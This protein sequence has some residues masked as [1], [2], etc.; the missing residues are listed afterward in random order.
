MAQGVVHDLEVVEVEEQDDRDQ[1]RGVGRLEAL[2]HALGEERPIGEAGQGI[3]VGLVLELLLEP[4]Q[5][6]ER[7]LQLA[8]LERDRRVA[9]E[10]LEQLE[11][12]G[13]ERTE[14]AQAVRDED[15]SDQARLADQR[16]VHRVAEA[17]P[18]L[19]GRLRLAVG[20]DGRRAAPRRTERASDRR[21]SSRSAA[22]CRP[23]RAARRSSG[24]CPDPRPGAGAIPRRS[25]PGTSCERDRGATRGPDPSP[26]CAGGSGSTRRASRGLRAA[27]APRRRRD[28]R[29]R[30]R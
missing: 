29:R 6:A 17:G 11:V 7:L 26:G 24:G 23:P 12:V 2:G 5:G 16:R 21:A 9:G 8:V 1:P 4:R 3:V 27:G 19:R 15:R 22:S 28:R 18:I 25:P 13:I 20:D 10:R 14:V 30:P